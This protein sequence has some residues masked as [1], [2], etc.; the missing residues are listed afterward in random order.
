MALPSQQGTSLVNKDP[1]ADIWVGQC[2]LRGSAPRRQ[3][4]RASGR[5]WR[6][7]WVAGH[8]RVPGDIPGCTPM[9]GKGPGAF[10]WVAGVCG[11]VYGGRLAMSNQ[12]KSGPIRSDQASA[13]GPQSGLQGTCGCLGGSLGAPRPPGMALGRF[14]GVWCDSPD[15][16]TEL[17]FG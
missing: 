11:P 16:K 10:W 6:P 3:V 14:G 15:R 9:R 1:C 8:L 7:K 4:V 12:V 5:F 13:H 2:G 17:I